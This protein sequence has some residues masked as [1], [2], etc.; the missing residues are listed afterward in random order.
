LSGQRADI[1]TGA[2]RD[3]AFNFIADLFDGIGQRKARLWASG[4]IL[5]LHANAA[6]R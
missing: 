2:P 1:F 6:R 3:S 5:K 4:I